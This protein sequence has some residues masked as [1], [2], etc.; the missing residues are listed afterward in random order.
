MRVAAIGHPGRVMSAGSVRRISA[1][2]AVLLAGAMLVIRVVL[3]PFWQR[4]SPHE[5]RGWFRGNAGRIG[6]VMFPLGGAA[7]LSSTAAAVVSRDVPRAQRRSLLLAAACVGGVT[8][9][10]MVVNE[11]A[12]QQFIGSE[13]AVDEIPALLARWRRWHTVR[14]LL[15][16]GAAVSAVRGLADHRN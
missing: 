13:L 15:G 16:A 5:F 11:P 8:L 1:G 6:A 7:T 10:T 2:L 4:L 14:V 3:V 9:V 12:N